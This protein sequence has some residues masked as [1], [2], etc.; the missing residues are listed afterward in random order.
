M[1]GGRQ[2]EI[3]TAL[4]TKQTNK[5]TT[6]N[7]QK[8]KLAVPS[9]GLSPKAAASPRRAGRAPSAELSDSVSKYKAD[10]F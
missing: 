6:D 1:R 8:Q 3:E 2:L 7:K 4:K 5:T 9:E 10:M